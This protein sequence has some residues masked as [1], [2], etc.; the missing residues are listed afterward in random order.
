MKPDPGRLPIQR[1]QEKSLSRHL[2]STGAP[3]KCHPMRLVRIHYTTMSR[4]GWYMGKPLPAPLRPR[5]CIRGPASRRNLRGGPKRPPRA[6]LEPYE[7]LYRALIHLPQRATKPLEKPQPTRATALPSVY[8]GTGRIGQDHQPRQPQ[9]P[10]VNPRERPRRHTTRRKANHRAS[11]ANPKGHPVSPPP[12]AAS[13]SEEARASSGAKPTADHQH[14]PPGPAAVSPSLQ[15]A[16]PQPT[17]RTLTVYPRT[18]KPSE[19]PQGPQDPQ[20]PQ[21]RRGNR[22]SPWTRSTTQRG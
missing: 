18:R 8:R 17:S 14:G 19:P 2:L 16:S 9:E 13:L 22:P 20:P 6:R 12:R 4:A 15:K 11:R 1:R 3:T 5:G 7:R 21:E 10:Q